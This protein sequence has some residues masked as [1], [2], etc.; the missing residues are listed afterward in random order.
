VTKGKKVYEYHCQK[1]GCRARLALGCMMEGG[2]LFPARKLDKD[3]KPNRENGSFG[4]HQGW[5]KFKGEPKE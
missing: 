5:T 4:P 2:R 1:P 3:G